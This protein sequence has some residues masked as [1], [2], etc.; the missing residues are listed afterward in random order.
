MLLRPLGHVGLSIVSVLALSACDQKKE[1]EKVEEKTPVKTAEQPATAAPGLKTDKGVDAASKT[2][3]IGALNDESGPAAA[4]G[5]PYALGKRILA[6]EVNAGGSGIL[7][8]GWKVQLIEKDHGYDPAK[9]Q[10][11]FESV[12]NDVLYFATSFGTP[13][14]MPLRP[15]LEKESIVAYPASLSSQMAEFAFTPPAGPSYVIEAARAADWVAGK[16]DKSKIKAGI[17]YDQT[18]YGADGLAGWKKGTAA[19]GLTIAVERAVKPGQK[20]FTAE[21]SE[22]KNAG[23]THVFLAILPS[24]TG[25]VLGTAAKLSF[26]PTWI[27][28]T[29]AWI[30]AFFAHPKLPAA[31]FANFYL[32]TGLPYWAEPVPGMDK[33]LAAFEKHGKAL[34]ARPDSYVLMSYL[35]GRIGL[36]AARRAIESGDATRAGYLASL[37]SLKGFEAG[38]LLQPLDFSSLPYVTST[39]ARILAPDFTKTTWRVDSPYAEPTALGAKTE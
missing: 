29:P 32:A 10:E 31:V 37:K 4:I 18:D 22:L 13:P 21:I 34:N 28:A 7:P 1:P 9:S 26:A 38:G 25:P 5:V 35:Q 3:R 36:E 16:G 30:D 14:T 8:E 24:S 39:K 19:N 27:G 20:D 15:F 12:K 11:A 2:I 17:L 33:F 6:E 23:I